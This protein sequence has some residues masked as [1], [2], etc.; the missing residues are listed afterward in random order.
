VNLLPLFEHFLDAGGQG[1]GQIMDHHLGDV[2]LHLA[3]RQAQEIFRVPGGI[4]DLQPLADQHHQRH[5]V[6]GQGLHEAVQHAFLL[7]GFH[8][9]PARQPVSPV[10][11]FELPR[12][13]DEG[14][15]HIAWLLSSPG[16]VDFPLVV[17][18][19]EV[20]GHLAGGFAG[21]QQ[22]DTLG[23]E[24]EVE[25]LQRFFLQHRLKI[26][27]QVA[28]A[29]QVDVG[30]GRILDNVV[31]CEYHQFADVA[32]DLEVVRPAVEIPGEQFGG[33]VR[34]DAFGVF[35]GAGPLQCVAVDVGGE[36]FDVHVPSQLH[37][38][39]P[40]DDCQ[41]IGLL[42][43]GATG[44]PDPQLSFIRVLQQSRK[45]VFPD[46]VKGLGVSEKTGDADEQLPVEGRH[47]TRVGF[48]VGDIFPQAV[49]LVDRHAALDAPYHGAGFV[50][51]EIHRGSLPQQ[52]ED[53]GQAVF[54]G[55]QGLGA[56]RF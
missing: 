17:H 37:Q 10:N 42:P 31:A 1:D 13:L 14:I 32:P 39:L 46:F 30:E 52:G 3:V 36:N 7:E 22:Q 8:G 18:G 34:G 33:K 12:N 20:V 2:V 45:P 19:F 29:Q 11:G 43:G 56:L 15:A 4:K 16:T 5:V 9:T 41:G 35:A 28:A 40:D 38:A 54:V 49:D 23:V 26:D 27:E 44:H 53:A 21:S 55:D 48:Q 24:R 51:G 47:L 25:Q 6:G 50:E